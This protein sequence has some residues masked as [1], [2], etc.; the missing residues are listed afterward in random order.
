M[1]AKASIADQ[2]RQSDAK[3]PNVSAV[4]LAKQ[5]GCSVQTVY[6]ARYIEREKAKQNGHAANSEAKPELPP[7]ELPPLSHVMTVKTAAL[8]VGGTDQLRAAID[9]YEQLIA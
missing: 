6:S 2:V 9:A 3:R 5:L 4:V 7:G 1:I 8:L